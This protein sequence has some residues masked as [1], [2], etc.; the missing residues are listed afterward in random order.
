MTPMADAEPIA[1]PMAEEAAEEAEAQAA[2]VPDLRDGE[3]ADELMLSEEL[4]EEEASDELLLD[5]GSMLEEDEG[6]GFVERGLANGPETAAPGN[7]SWITGED[8]P[9]AQPAAPKP[10]RDGGTLFE[11]MSNIARGA[12]KAQVEEEQPAPGRT[13]D[14]LDIP[15]FLGRQNNQ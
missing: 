10:A 1:E 11:R 2:S 7:R 15:R 8:M 9:A 12:A 14:P 6:A 4:A 3:T 13:R 5:A